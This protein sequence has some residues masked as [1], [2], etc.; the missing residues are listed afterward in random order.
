MTRTGTIR[1]MSRSRDA[2][3]PELVEQLRA[4]R[5][6]DDE[7]EAEYELAHSR[8]KSQVV[9]ALAHGSVRRVA[10]AASLSPTTVQ[11]WSKETSAEPIAKPPV[12]EALSPQV[13]RKPVPPGDNSATSGAPS[14]P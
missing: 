1:R 12:D 7:A 9:A 10:E 2:L 8:F 6:Q 5:R 13:A 4:A 14:R 3:P 11:A